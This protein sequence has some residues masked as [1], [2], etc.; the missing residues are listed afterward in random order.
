ML[1]RPEIG[2]CARVHYPEYGHVLARSKRKA[3]N[4]NGGSPRRSLM[5]AIYPYGLGFRLWY[6]LNMCRNQVATS[7]RPHF[8]RAVPAVGRQVAIGGPVVVPADVG[9]A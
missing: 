8:K 3:T 4:P 1:N 5:W 9:S 7:V 2:D 6:R